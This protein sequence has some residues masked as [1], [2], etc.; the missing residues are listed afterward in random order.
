MAECWKEVLVLITNFFYQ[1]ISFPFYWIESCLLEDCSIYLL[2]C[3]N[4][5]SEEY[6]VCSLLR[7]F[8]LP[9]MFIRYFFDESLYRVGTTTC[10]DRCNFLIEILIQVFGA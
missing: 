10:F 8:F 6:I 3:G 2:F 7:D 1:R 4:F 9:R 5:V